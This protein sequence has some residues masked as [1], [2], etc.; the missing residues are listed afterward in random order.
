MLGLDDDIEFTY[1]DDGGK[2]LVV[3]DES[4][5][6]FVNACFKGTSELMMQTSEASCPFTKLLQH[7]LDSF[8][9]AMEETGATDHFFCVSF[10]PGYPYSTPT[11]TH[12]N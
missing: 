7:K 4:L 5:G 6:T 3:V 2:F 8:S 12:Y 10:I 11:Q 1:L 9:H